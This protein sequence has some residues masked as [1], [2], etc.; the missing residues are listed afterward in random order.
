[1]GI[2]EREERRETTYPEICIK[3]SR[4]G[5]ARPYFASQEHFRFFVTRKDGV[6]ISSRARQHHFSRREEII[7]IGMIM[8]K[9]K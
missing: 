3:V 7:V 5:N 1:M 4:R 9:S 2:R 8:I 6:G